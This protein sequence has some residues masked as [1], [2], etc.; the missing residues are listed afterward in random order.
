VEIY[1]DPQWS[2]S[3]DYLLTRIEYFEGHSWAVVPVT[4]SGFPTRPVLLDAFGAEA[5]WTPD[6]RVLISSRGGSQSPR[7]EAA[8]ISLADAPDDG[9]TTLPDALIL[10]QQTILQRPVADA[11]VRGGDQFDLLLL[12]DPFGLGPTSLQ[13]VSAGFSGDLLPVSRAFV[14]DQPQLGPDGTFVAGLSD[15]QFD[16]F[17]SFNGGRLTLF[18]IGSNRYSIIEGVTNVRDLIWGR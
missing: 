11:V 9:W 2:P 3:G 4:Q 10:E 16:E 1:T 5:Q 13:I 18:D 15:L 7:A 8:V 17:G 14:L 6:N 12:P